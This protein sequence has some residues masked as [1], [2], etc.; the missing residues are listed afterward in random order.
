MEQRVGLINRL[1]CMTQG[2]TPPPPL[3]ERF[4]SRAEQPAE[5]A[6]QQEPAQPAQQPAQQPVW[7]PDP[8][9]NGQWERGW[10]GVKWTEHRRQNPR[11]TTC[12]DCAGPI[13][14]TARICQRCGRDAWSGMVQPDVQYL[15]RISFRIGFIAL[16]VLVGL[17]VSFFIGASL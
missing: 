9:T 16:V 14:V 17:V 11:L 13:S 1:S 7:Y 4:P 10:D 8:D 5:P 2:P 15:S 12:P 3:P 6:T